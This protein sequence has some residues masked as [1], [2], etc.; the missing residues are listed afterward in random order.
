MSSVTDNNGES[1][2]CFVCFG[3]T[4]AA[5]GPLP[6]P[7]VFRQER[8]KIS[9]LTPGVNL[10]AAGLYYLT[11][12]EDIGGATG[13]SVDYDVNVEAPVALGAIINVRKFAPFVWQIQLFT[14]SDPGP[15]V[16]ALSDLVAN[17][18][19]AIVNVTLKRVDP[20]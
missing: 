16:F 10:T 5:E 17:N 7:N 15:A 12:V 4:T 14:I 6:E 9:R 19:G 18:V 8:C 11:A 2:Q 13:E 20:A 1:F 3:T